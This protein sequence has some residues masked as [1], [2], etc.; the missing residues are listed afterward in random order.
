MIYSCGSYCGTIC[1]SK[2]ESVV[3]YEYNN[4]VYIAQTN[5]PWGLCCSEKL[6]KFWAF[7]HRILDILVDD[8][9]ITAISSSNG[10]LHIEHVSDVF[11]RLDQNR[12]HLGVIDRV[13]SVRT[14][15]D[16]GREI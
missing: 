5:Y 10:S 11:D 1:F 12:H 2:D 3:I 13:Q 9:V 16:E 6:S 4:R 15:V 7:R 8:H 14:L